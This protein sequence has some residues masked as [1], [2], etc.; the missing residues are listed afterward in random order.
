MVRPFSRRD[1][2]PPLAMRFLGYSPCKPDGQPCAPVHWQRYRQGPDQHWQEITWQNHVALSFQHPQIEFLADH[3]IQ[4]Q[5]FLGDICVLRIKIQI[6]AGLI[7][8]LGGGQ[9]G[10]WSTKGGS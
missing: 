10:I 3:F 2:Q 1:I 7:R 5:Y 9:P 6:A 4:H 8:W